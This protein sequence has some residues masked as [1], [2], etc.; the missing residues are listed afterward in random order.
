[1]FGIY[2]VS[3]TAD[4]KVRP[5][6]LPKENEEKTFLY[7]IS[8]DGHQVLYSRHKKNADGNSVTQLYLL[9]LENLTFTEV[10]NINFYWEFA[11]GGVYWIP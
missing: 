1:L 7:D 2:E 8:P 5:F 11:L 9:D 10:S 3:T 6:H 4:L